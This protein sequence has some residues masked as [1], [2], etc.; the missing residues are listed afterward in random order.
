MNDI[1]KSTEVWLSCNQNSKEEAMKNVLFL[2]Q[3]VYF[4]SNS[5]TK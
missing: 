1:N 2:L 4:E 5:E 3:Q